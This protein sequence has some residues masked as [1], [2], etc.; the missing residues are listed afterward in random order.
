[1]PSHT[2]QHV[3]LQIMLYEGYLS[4]LFLGQSALLQKS[5]WQLINRVQ[6]IAPV[7]GHVA[8]LVE[9]DHDR[10]HDYGNDRTYSTFQCLVNINMPRI[11]RNGQ[12]K[13]QNFAQ[14]SGCC[15]QSQQ[16]LELWTE[17]T[18]TDHGHQTSTLRMTADIVL[19]LFH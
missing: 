10:L 12:D 8:E 16:G 13:Q 19:T 1:M 5:R 9:I 2:L 14:V 7:L 15:S 6:V 18:G 4:P 3:H 17:L 11:I